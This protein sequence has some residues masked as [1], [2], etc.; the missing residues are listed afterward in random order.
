MFIQAWDSVGSLMKIDLPSL[1]ATCMHDLFRVITVEC[2]LCG[3]LGKGNCNTA[4]NIK[5]STDMN[6]GRLDK[7][8]GMSFVLL[9]TVYCVAEFKYMKYSITVL[10]SSIDVYGTSYFAT[11]IFLDFTVLA[12]NCFIFDRNKQPE[13]PLV[14]N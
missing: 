4:N 2:P 6:Y 5:P 10:W 9:Y 1:Y 7:K 8:V 3:L 12:H 13:H 14:F 11:K